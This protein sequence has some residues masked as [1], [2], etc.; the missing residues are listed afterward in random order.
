MRSVNLIKV[1]I[2]AEV[3]R[4]KTMAARQGR[5]AGFGIAALIFGVGFLITLE[6]AGWQTARMYILPIYATLCVMGFNFLIAAGFAMV[7]MRSRP[8]RSEI[9]A[10]A[11]RKRAVQAL[12]TSLTISA[13][14]PAA[15]YL[16]DRRGRRRLQ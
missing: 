10:L 13:L 14:I 12:Q 16:W 4:Y 5:R 6:I 3:L 2:E 7:A 15:G 11:V 1:V 9:E 8:S